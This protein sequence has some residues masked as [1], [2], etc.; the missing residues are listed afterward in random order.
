MNEKMRSK[1]MS[2]KTS[3]FEIRNRTFWNP[4]YCISLIF[5]VNSQF[6]YEIVYLTN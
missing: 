6:D 5:V 2:V 3:V 1:F 4:G